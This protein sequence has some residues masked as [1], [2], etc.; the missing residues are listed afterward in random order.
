MIADGLKIKVDWD[1]W[2]APY[3]FNLIQDKGN[4]P[5]DD[6]RRSF[7]LGLGMVLVVKKES[8]SKFE[9]YLKNEDEKYFLIGELV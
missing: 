9:T 1:A 4:V 5:I 7:N 3:I 6:M 2:E 8:L